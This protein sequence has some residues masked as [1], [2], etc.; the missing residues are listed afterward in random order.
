MATR[1]IKKRVA[2]G[3]V[4]FLILLS[5]AIVWKRVHNVAIEWPR[6]IAFKKHNLDTREIK[7]SQI[8]EPIWFVK[9]KNQTVAVFVRFKNE[10]ARN[11]KDQPGLL[12]L[13]L[14]LLMKGAGKYDTT[15]LRNVLD[16]NSIDFAVNV[17]KDDSSFSL[18]LVPEKFQLAMEIM[19]DVLISA[20]FPEE[21]I[22]TF[23]Q[24]IKSELNQ[25]KV[26]PEVIAREEMAKLMYSPDH[27]YYVTN[28]DI[29]QN[30][31]KYTRN[32]VIKAYNTLFD[33][34][35]AYVIVAGNISEEEVTL[36]FEK[37]FATLKMHKSNA[38]DK[39]EQKT[40]MLKH[41]E[42]VHI[43]HDIPQTIVRFS[44]PGVKN[45]SE[46]WFAATVVALALG[47]GMKSRLFIELREKH[48]L[49]YDVVAG[50]AES[51]MLCLIEGTAG[52]DPQ[53]VDELITRIKNVFREL[54]DKGVTQEELDFKKNLIAE[55]ENLSS[56]PKVV[57]FLSVCR[58]RKVPLS[59]VNGY[60]R[61]FY[62]LKLE[63]VNS[64]ARRLLDPNKLTF[65]AIGRR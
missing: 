36:A 60:R 16:E 49:V 4:G 21:K 48:S 51:D 41:G 27:P 54:A 56:A 10:G 44:H 63:D 15:E 12:N 29:L 5:G 61:N 25:E 42:I 65:V 20:H 17:G 32:D 46:D 62:N 31:D 50:M 2:C 57:S 3:I 34:R 19:Q 45:D 22:T 14:S 39:V 13:L 52:T 64:V 47:D 33:P 38:F 9:T 30:I 1:H 55:S 59:K 6:N 43:N 18:Y 11:F 28:N 35:N 7:I 37:L 24:E 58:H 23:K 26:Y 8:D 40:E 53:N